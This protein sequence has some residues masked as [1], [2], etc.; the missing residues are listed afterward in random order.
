MNLSDLQ[1]EI[2]IIL[3][4]PTVESS[5]TS[6]LN[7]EILQLSYQY[8][9]PALKVKRPFVLT[10]TNIEWLY[11]MTTDV[12]H[13]EGFVYQK[14][15]WRITNP[16]VDDADIPV[17]RLVETIDRLDPNHDETATDISRA[18]VEDDAIAVFPM[19]NDS[20]NIWAFRAPI[21][22]SNPTDVPDGI[23]EAFHYRVLVPRVILRMFKVY[24]ELATEG[25]A[26]DSLRALQL[27]TNRLQ[28]GL[29]GDG[30]EMGMLDALRKNRP[31]RIRGPRSGGNLAG[32]DSFMRWGW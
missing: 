18:A 20:L 25:G 6:F 14:M 10:T 28:A 16:S 8:D 12:T 13:V 29:Y 5:I 19:A 1:T 3:P 27:W 31:P 11:S 24:P 21:A 26:G 2:Q 23:P 22:M 17:D 30:G 15:V 7:D 4:D 9:L 32:A